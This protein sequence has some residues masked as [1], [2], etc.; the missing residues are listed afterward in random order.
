MN[1]DL[2]ETQKWQVQRLIEEFQ[3]IFTDKPRITNLGEHE[4]KLTVE[5]PIR[6]KPYTLP[7]A[8]RVQLCNY[9]L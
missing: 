7:Y 3:D 1:P 5:D 4:M 8:M 6:S 9:R 2:S